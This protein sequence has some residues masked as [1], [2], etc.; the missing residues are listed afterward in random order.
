LKLVGFGI[1]R[2]DPPRRLQLA[3]SWFF[4]DQNGTVGKPYQPVI[5]ASLHKTRQTREA[6]TP[7]DDEIDAL[8]PS[9][10]FNLLCGSASQSHTDHAAGADAASRQLIDGGPDQLPCLRRVDDVPDDAP[11]AI[12]LTHMQ[13]QHFRLAGERNLR[14][15]RNRGARFRPPTN[16]E[17]QPGKHFAS[18]GALLRQS[19]RRTVKAVERSPRGAAGQKRCEAEDRASTNKVGNLLPTRLPGTPI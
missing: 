14:R 9:H 13:N 12:A 17:Q 7:H 15:R 19:T 1:P 8:I 4:G 18:Q 2:F 6:T 16:G 10:S 3:S 5:D 11:C